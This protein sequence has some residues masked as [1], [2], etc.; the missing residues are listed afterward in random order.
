[1]LVVSAL[2]LK[3]M[4]KPRKEVV[5]DDHGRRNVRVITDERKYWRH[6][7]KKPARKAE[8]VA[9]WVGAVVVCVITI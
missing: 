2:K 8:K 6:Q 5:V 7:L 1:L 9:L 4:R 3:R